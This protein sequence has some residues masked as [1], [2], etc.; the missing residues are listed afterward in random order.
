[1]APR[2]APMT[3]E[4]FL[5][6]CRQYGVTIDEIRPTQGFLKLSKRFTPGSKEGYTGAETDVG[7]I[8]ETPTAG[9]GSVWGT[10]GGSVGGMIG[11]TSGH[12]HLSKSN[13]SKRFL[14]ALA[15]INK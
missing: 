7:L 1:M 8:Y 10:D 2:A 4:T 11:L 5:A 12:M 3:A 13:V 9:D 6:K 15:K 14:A